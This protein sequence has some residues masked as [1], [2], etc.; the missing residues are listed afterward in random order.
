MKH[1]L[2]FLSSLLLYLSFHPA[3]FG[4]LVWIALVPLIVWAV[5]ETKGWR[6][7]LLGWA[8][9]WLFY[10]TSLWWITYTAPVFGPVGVGLYK[11]LYWGLFAA[12]VRWACRG[13]RSPRVPIVVAAPVLWLAFEFARCYVMGG[14][15][16]VVVGYAAHRLDSFIQIADLGGIWLVTFVVVLVNATLARAFL[17]PV[18]DREYRWSAAASVVVL[19]A[20][21]VYGSVRIATIRLEDGLRIGIV[22][23]NI[24]QDVK[25]LSKEDDPRVKLQI[26]RKHMELTRQVAERKPDVIFWPEAAL[27][28]SL[29]VDG[30]QWD[31]DAYYL[32]AQAPAV[33]NGI[34][35]VLGVQII[36]KP[37][38]VPLTFETFGSTATVTNSAVY[39]DGDG[40]LVARYDKR[41]LVHFSEYMP[42]GTGPIVAR[43]LNLRKVYEFRRGTEFTVMPHP[44]GDFAVTI[45]SE[46][47]YPEISREFAR[48]GVRTL[49]N[50]SND[51]WFR[52]SAELDL[53]MSMA[54]F[55][56]IENR[57]LYVR[58]TNTGISALVDPLG[59]VTALVAGPDGKQKGVEGTLA[60]VGKVTT[61]GSPWR[62]MGDW[63][64]WLCAG[65]SLGGLVA[66]RMSRK[67]DS[68]KRQP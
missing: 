18:R 41:R 40:N 39:F 32:K 52:E 31:V 35:V 17:G 13:D 30:G 15:P 33:E 54:R 9:G 56:A 19:A 66:L 6:A 2:P 28:Y 44:K 8:A 25:E 1:L 36:D 58:A 68:E 49:V 63:A 24:P 42:M 57:V 62:T 43:Y 23:P 46:N 10:A 50:I 48:K 4:F 53:Q 11:G 47:Y 26:Y 22:Q 61:D 3:D 16:F 14:L 20:S 59:R 45:C 7:F 21:I 65:L 51:G 5:R 29:I 64:A 38:G 60:E 37:R 12:I 34:P 55:R 67:I 27:L